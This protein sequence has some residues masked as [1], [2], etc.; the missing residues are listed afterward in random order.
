MAIIDDVILQQRW[1]REELITRP[2]GSGYNSTPY[3]SVMYI[4]ISER[5]WE[6]KGRRKGRGEEQR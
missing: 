3:A 5:M 1:G 2:G 6:W 4:Y